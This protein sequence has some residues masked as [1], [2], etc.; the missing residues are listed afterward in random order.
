MPYMSNAD[1]NSALYLDPTLVLYIVHI[2]KSCGRT[3][4]VT[5]LK[6]IIHDKLSS[7]V[8]AI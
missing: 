8:V 5:G 4:S 1:S 6:L 3:I 2:I 7:I